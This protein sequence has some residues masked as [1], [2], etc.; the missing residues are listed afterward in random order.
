MGGSRTWGKRI[1][2]DM[3]FEFIR[4]GYKRSRRREK[5]GLERRGKN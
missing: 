2:G 1:K 4:D 5:R 3:I